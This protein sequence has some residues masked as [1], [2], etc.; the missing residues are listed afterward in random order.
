MSAP[1]GFDLSPRDG[2]GHAGVGATFGG[3][4]L[5]HDPSGLDGVDVAVL[6]AP[7]DD[8]TSNRPGARFGPRAIRG[9]DDGGRYGR[10]HMTLG[11]DPFAELNVVDY[12]DAEVAPADLARSHAYLEL[13]LR[14]ILGAGAVPLVLGGDHSLSLPTMRVVAERHG[15]DGYAVLHFD[16][17]ADT[18]AELY[19]VRLSHGTPFRV[20]VEEGLLRGDH[21]VQGGLRGTWPGPEEFDWMSAQGFRWHTMGEIDERGLHAVVGEAVQAVGQAAPRVYMTVDIDVLDPAFAPGTGTPEPGGLTTRELLWAVR[22]SARELDLCAATWSKSARRTTTPTSRRWRPRGWR[23]RYWPARPRAAA[24]DRAV[25]PHR[26]AGAPALRGRERLAHHGDR[27]CRCDRGRAHRRAHAVDVHRPRPRARRELG[28]RLGVARAVAARAGAGSGRAGCAGRGGAGGAQP[29][30]GDIRRGEPGRANRGANPGRVRGAPGPASSTQP[31]T[32]TITRGGPAVY[33]RVATSSS[34]P[35]ARRCIA[36]T[37]PLRSTTAKPA[38]SS[39]TSTSRS[40]GW[41]ANRKNVCKLCPQTGPNLAPYSRG[42]WFVRPLSP[43]RW[44][45]RLCW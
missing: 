5:V 25:R 2:P 44:L 4:P 16:T 24:V 6:G 32:A 42:L 12:G 45:R 19:G 27:R 8:G 13:R 43:Q 1:R 36:C 31:S 14:E 40:L 35:S 28:D 21:I 18:A 22:H 17:H 20:A 33:E 23:S 29:A 39:A 15:T 26:A 11:L 9:A 38:V 3:R 37:R 30:R 7:F 41:R 34:R 10:P